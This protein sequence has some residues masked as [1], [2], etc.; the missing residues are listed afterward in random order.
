MYASTEQRSSE[1]VHVLAEELHREHRHYLMRIAIKNAA[2]RDDAEEAVQFAFLA[3]L[4]HFDPNGEAPPLAWL[5]L[6]LKRDCWARYKRRRLDR[7]ANREV[8]GGA[9]INSIPSRATA[10]EQLVAQ[11]EEARAKLAILKPQELRALSLLA[12]GYTYQ[13][14]AAINQWTYTKVNRCIAE[15]RAALRANAATALREQVA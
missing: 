13:E 8:A 4:E 9:L 15:G 2:N 12:T 5:T 3:F 1:R 10:P 6:A 7:S 14:I 11:V